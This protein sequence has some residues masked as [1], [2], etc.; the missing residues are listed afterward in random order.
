MKYGIYSQTTNAFLIGI[1]V[2][3]IATFLLSELCPAEI[4]RQML[5][6]I[7]IIIRETGSALTG[8]N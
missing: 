4:K 5:E 8:S 7:H 6:K 1:N 3:H 2:S